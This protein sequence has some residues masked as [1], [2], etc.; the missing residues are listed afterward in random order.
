ML[1]GAIADSFAKILG[2]TGESKLRSSFGIDFDFRD[3]EQGVSAFD[4][5][6]L[7]RSLE[8]ELEQITD[9]LFR[10]RS[11]GEKD[12]LVVS[13]IDAVKELEGTFTDAL[14]SGAGEPN[15]ILVDLSV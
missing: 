15:G 9:F 7:S 3:G 1:S 8:T 11:S 5:R 10:E 4:T 12:G 6:T 2:E 14:H 13:L